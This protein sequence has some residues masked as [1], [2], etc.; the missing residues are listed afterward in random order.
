MTEYFLK[1][2]STNSASRWLTEDV[3]KLIDFV[4]SDEAIYNPRHKYY[5]CRPYVENFWRQ[6]DQKL[7]KNRKL[8]IKKITLFTFLFCS[9]SMSFQMDQFKNF[10]S[11]GIYQLPCGKS[12]S[13]LVIL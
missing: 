10:F 11:S 5:F 3:Y 9:W 2:S 1:A 6:V 7:E 12:S 4:K 13:V 8:L